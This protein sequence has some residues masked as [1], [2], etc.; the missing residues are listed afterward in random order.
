ML[1]HDVNFNLE[2]LKLE[3]G[4]WLAIYNSIIITCVVAFGGIFFTYFT[5]PATSLLKQSISHRI[6]LDGFIIAYTIL[7]SPILCL[8]RPIHVTMARIRKKIA[9]IKASSS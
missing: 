5:S 3:H 7:G 1:G 4:E 6:Y 8:L 9:E 2:T